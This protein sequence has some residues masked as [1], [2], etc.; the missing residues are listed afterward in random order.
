[1]VEAVVDRMSD[2]LYGQRVRRTDADSEEDFDVSNVTTM[3]TTADY[4]LQ[5]RAPYGS[6]D[7]GELWF[8]VILYKMIVPTLFGVVAFVG[9][10]G[11]AMVIYVVLSRTDMRRNAVNLLLLNLAARSVSQR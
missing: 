1:M 6:I 7:D 5:S 11:N 2:V 4:E 3:N 8:Y 9:L 10:V